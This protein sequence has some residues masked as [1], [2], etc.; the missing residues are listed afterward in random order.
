MLNVG[1]FLSAHGPG[2]ETCGTDVPFH[3]VKGAERT[4]KVSLQALPPMNHAWES[5]CVPR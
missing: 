4:I 5:L 2:A 1:N 3:C